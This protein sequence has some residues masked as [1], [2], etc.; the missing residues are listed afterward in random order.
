MKRLLLALFLAGLG[1]TAYGQCPPTSPLTTPYSENFDSESAGHQTTFGNCY[2]GTTSTNPRW[3]YENSGTGNSTGTGPLND[4]SGTGLYAYLECSGGALGD[5]AGLILPAIDLSSLTTPELSFQY[6]MFG[7]NM[8][9]LEVY[10]NDGTGWTQ[11]FSISGEQQSSET[12]AWSKGIVS[13]VAYANSTVRIKFLGSRGNGYESD[14]SIDEISVDEAPACPQPTNFRVISTGTTTAD[15]TFN[16]VSAA[17]SGYKVLTGAPGFNPST[18]TPQTFTNDTVTVTGLNP[19]SNYEAYIVSDCATNGISDTTGPISFVTSCV[20]YN[21]NYTRDFESDND[22][23]PALCWSE[24][25][26]FSTFAYGR[27]E[28]LSTFN[29]PQAF[30]GSNVLEFYSYNGTATDTVMA[31]SPEFSDMTSNSRQVKFQIASQSPSNTLLVGTTNSQTPGSPISW[32]DTISN[33]SATWQLYIL[34]L[35]AGNGYNGNDK[36][37]V[38]RHGMENTFSDIY[39]DDFTYEAIP[40]CPQLTNVSLSSVGI[41]TASFSYNS[42]GNPVQYEWGPV[43]YTQGTGTVGS[44]TAGAGTISGLSSASCYDVYLRTDCTGS[45]NGTSVWTGPFTLCTLC[46]TQSLPYSEDFEIGLGCFVAQDG[47][48]TADTWVHATTTT[49]TTDPAG[50]DGSTGW[51]EADSDN[52]GSGAVT[53]DETLISPYVDAG[54]IAGTLY[55]EFDQ[56]HRVLGSNAIVDVWDGNSWVNLQNSNASIGNFGNPDHQRINITQYANDSLQVRF[57]YQDNGSWAWWWLIDNVLIHEELCA[58]STNFQMT[59]ATADSIGL[60]WNPGAGTNFG[61]EFGPAGFTPG[62]GTTV[63]TTDSTITITGL[64]AQT[65]YD[66]YLTDSCSGGTASLPVF[67]SASTACA[68]STPANLPLVEDFE[69]YTQGP[70]FTTTDY[71]CNT[72]HFW[73]LNPASA[74]SRFRLQAGATYFRNGLQAL[75]L[76]HGSFASQLETNQTVMTVDLSNYTTAN[77]I[78]LSFYWMRHTTTSR[79]G[80]KVYARGSDNDPW[81]ELASLNNSVSGQY[82]SII[83]LDIVA[84]L[85]LAGQMVGPTTQI[86]FDQE[87]QNSSSFSNTCCDGYTLDDVR[88]EAVACPLPGGLSVSN[89]F[90]TTATLNWAGAS[91]AS[92][93][94]YWFGPAGFF[95]GTTTTGGAKGFSS[96]SGVVVDTLSQF[97]CYEFLV[98]TV[99]QPG[100]TSSW[101]TPFQFCTPCSPITAPY[102]ENWDALSSGQKDLGCFNSIEDP[103]FATSTFIGVSIQSNT[104]YNPNSPLNYVEMDNS[105]LNTAPLALVSPPTTDMDAGDKRLVFYSRATSTLSPASTLI[106]GTMSDGNDTSTFNGLDTIPVDGAAFTRYVVNLTSNNG[107][108]GSD[109][110]FAFV[111]GNDATFRTILI[112][113]VTYEQIPSCP[114]VSNLATVQVDSMNADITWTP[115]SGSTGTF[116]VEYGTSNFGA[117]SHNRVIAN[118]DTTTLTGLTPGTNYCFW[119]REICAPGDTSIWIGPN[120]FKTECLTISAPSS[121]NWD[122]LASGLDLGCFNKYEDPSLTPSAF[123]GVTV[124]NG[125][126]NQPFS[127]PNTVELDNGSITSDDLMLISPRTNDLTASDKRVRFYARTTNTFNSPE[128]VVGTITNPLDPSTFTAIDTIALQ[129]GAM[130]EYIVNLD[131]ANG[132]NGSDDYFAFAHGLTST[133]QPIFMD[134]IYYEAIPTCLRPDSLDVTG[135]TTTSANVSWSSVVG[136]S[137]FEYEYGINPLGDPNNSRLLTTNSQVSLSGLSAGTGY[138]VWV[139]E[140]CSPGDTSFWRGPFCFSTLCASSNPAPYFTNFEGI[141]IGVASGTPSGWE[142]CWTHVQGSGT[143]RWESED[144]TGANENS[145]ATG[146]FND[147]TRPNAPGGTYMY[148]ETSSSG[149][150]SELISPPIDITGLASPEVEYWYHMHGATINRLVVYAEDASGTRTAIDSLVGQ[151]QTAQSDPFWQRN[152]SIANLSPGVYTFVFEGHRGTSFTGDISIDDFSVQVG[153]TCPRPTFLTQ[154]AKNLND[155]TIAWTANGTG[156]SWEIE[157]GVSGFTP[158]SGSTLITTNNPVTINSLT[159]ATNYDVYVREI[160]AP[161]DTSVW[162]GPLVASTDICLASSKCWYVFD[163]KDT[164]GDGWNGGEI[165]IYQNGIEVGSLGSNFT[166]GSL[167]TDSIELCDMLSTSVAL[168]NAGGWPSEIGLDVFDPTGGNVGTYV[169]SGLTAQGDTLVSFTSNCAGATTPCVMPD[170]IW[171]TNNIACDEIEV[172]WNSNTGGSILE[173]GPAGFTPGTGTVTGIVTAPYMI[174]SLSPGTAYDVYVADTC[175][176]DTSSFN[177]FSTSTASGPLPSASFTIDSAIVGNAYEV[178]VDASASTDADSYEWNFGN[179]VT[180]T[181][182]ADTMIYLGNGSYTIT[183]IVSNACGSDTLSFTTFANVGLAENPLANSLSVF[184]NPANYEV[185]VNFSAVGSADAVI[186]LIDAQG[187]EVKF[188]NERSAAG[189]FNYTMDVSNLASGIYMI[190]IQSGDLNA[191][192]RLSVK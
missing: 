102:T 29:N 30:S 145:L 103:S 136:G 151:Q 112:D 168:T 113:D 76:D 182:V 171:A 125:T 178:Y 188:S 177:M 160:C 107:Y 1:T 23:V 189:E 162:T 60:F 115:F 68:I 135:I 169:A 83:G 42:Q 62:A 146:P 104:F 10:V 185:T 33:L 137:N 69:S 9:D 28:T 44:I 122:G 158:G 134:D 140:I 35:N 96:T 190:E 3:E 97:T 14:M 143:V 63:S 142:N 43:G 27:V 31:I 82:D 109:M 71:L 147:A 124:Q 6:H 138:C 157:Y 128:L 156:T 17:T 179:G 116:E 88:L 118:N 174:N 13:L 86:R 95:Q 106:V 144:A 45:S 166:T 183:L 15:L 120:C 2:I 20:P 53:M 192:R 80:N 26:S 175:G 50:L 153:S 65:A 75:T 25:S 163:L 4:F 173:Y 186:R 54:N 87:G 36:F 105:N 79:P 57:V 187:R 56:F 85:A 150:P 100:D 38:F 37:L 16:S 131:A 129:N 73:A 170:S 181:N 48:N 141:S 126:F 41:T 139:R 12:A 152:V 119:V 98:R 90:D 184:P 49:T 121:E 114:E 67:L 19:A 47:G 39:I 40:A 164:F 11:E 58:R 123:Q 99:C 108:N 117:G 66:F 5:T 55:L 167:F 149:G 81:V 148:L 91:S 52:A 130:V 18:A 77:G 78:E 101:S 74:N 94:Q 46:L 127:A 191:R 180:S 159:A 59:F 8:G 165:T 24:Y 155:I 89:V 34:P 64:S 154:T 92:N 22:G 84:P 93:F 21:T 51:V 133:F 176:S 72:G 161:G 32:I 110:F 7:V 61:I 172:D 132:Y 111:H 70:T